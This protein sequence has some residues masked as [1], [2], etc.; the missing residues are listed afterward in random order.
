MC[1]VKSRYRIVNLCLRYCKIIKQS[2]GSI[3]LFYVGVV[4]LLGEIALL[5]DLGLKSR[6]ERILVCKKV[7]CKNC[8]L[9]NKIRRLVVGVKLVEE[10]NAPALRCV[11]VDNK[12]DLLACK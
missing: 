3:K 6:T 7:L 10:Y 12:S 8:V 11:I 5:G 4:G 1:L 9:G 2:L